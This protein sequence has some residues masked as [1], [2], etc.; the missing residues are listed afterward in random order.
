MSRTRSC[1]T[2]TKT[3]G[4]AEVLTDRRTIEQNGPDPWSVG[5]IEGPEIR[6]MGLALLMVWLW[7]GQGMKAVR[8]SPR[9]CGFD[10]G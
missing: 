1:S 10:E 5:Q 3:G 9:L 8:R 7:I 6:H 4:W 2:W